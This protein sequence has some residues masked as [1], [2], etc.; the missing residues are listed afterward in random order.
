MVSDFMGV[1]LLAPN[2]NFT[3]NNSDALI[4]RKL[5]S[6]GVGY[7]SVSATLTLIRSLFGFEVQTIAQFTSRTKILLPSQ[8]IVSKQP[9][10]SDVHSGEGVTVIGIS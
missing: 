3:S 7:V 5:Y 4:K 2:T 10:T 6:D 9:I 1:L 8:I